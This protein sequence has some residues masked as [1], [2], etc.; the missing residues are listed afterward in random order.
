MLAEIAQ[1]EVRETTADRSRPWIFAEAGQRGFWAWA[2]R[3][4]NDTSMVL[5]TPE[6]EENISARGG[7]GRI[8][9]LRAETRCHRRPEIFFFAEMNR[10]RSWARPRGYAAEAGFEALGGT[11]GAVRRRPEVFRGKRK[12]NP[13][14][15]CR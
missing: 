13:R 11:L 2:V 9:G 14:R 1:K 6:F 7:E 12:K 4:S 8:L 3:S 5:T 15:A 10:R